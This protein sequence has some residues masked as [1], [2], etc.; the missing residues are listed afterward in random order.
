MRAHEDEERELIAAVRNLFTLPGRPEAGNGDPTNGSDETAPLSHPDEG[1]TREEAAQDTDPSGSG[2]DEEQSEPTSGPAPKRAGIRSLIDA[3]TGSG[4]TEDRHAA[5][6]GD[7]VRALLNRIERRRVEADAGGAPPLPAAEGIEAGPEMPAILPR[8]NDSSGILSRMK[9]W[10]EAD[11]LDVDEPGPDEDLNA[12]VVSVDDLGNLADLIL[13]KSATFAVEELNINRDDHHFD[14]VDNARVVSEFDDLFARTV[15]SPAF[16]AAAAQVAIP[17]EEGVQPR[18]GFLKKFQFPG[19]GEAI[20]E[21]NS[22]FHGPLVDLSMRPSPGL[23]EIELYPVN[24]PY[25]YVRVT[26]DGTTH[27]YTYHVLEPVL[28]PG[29]QEL[30]GEI[31]ERLF[32]TLDITTRDLTREAARKALRDSANTIIADYGIHLTP[33]GRE[34]ILYHVEKEFLGDGL[35]DPVMHDKY[36]EDISCD[37]VNSPIF[38]YHTTYESMKTSLVYRD[39][40]DLDSFVTKLAQRAGKYISIAEPMLDATMSDGSRIQMTLGA[41]VTAHGSTFTI[42]KFREE[43]ITPTDLI[44]WHTF[45]PLG[46]AFIWLAVENAKSCIFAGG[47]ASGK[48]TTLNA[49]SLFIP[50]LAKIVTLEDTR[51]LKLPHPNWIPSITRDSFSQDGRGEIDMYELLRAA[52]RQR[53]EYILVGEVRGREALTL[54]QAM[55]TGHVTYATMHADSVASAVHRLENPPIDVPRNML[56]ALSLMSIQVQAR[57]GG[58]RIRRNKQLIEILDIDPRTNELIT[59]EVFRWHPATDEIRYSGKSYILEQIMEDRG[60]SEE[61]MQEELKRRQEVLEWMRI[62]K[63]RYF[64]DV[65][66]ILV[67]YFRDPETV[68][69]RV[70]SDL[71]GEDGGLA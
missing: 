30:F 3:V 71:Y 14:F 17:A 15:S 49:I 4:S 57:V 27:E 61:R 55:S 68:I 29:E 5:G 33:P 8:Q 28:T 6:G 41:E 11:T 42:R 9:G 66:K 39:A 7:P 22:T 51:E 59:N 62:K 60:W 13:P 12:G 56:S 34:K 70:R 63:I 64:R 37:G 43:P 58:Q 54:F 47:T 16:V 53:P 21:Y 50:P 19:A 10:R 48:T 67:S 32:E 52:L 31:K 20:E 69:E 2:G 44:E 1:E 40:A 45:S 25:A 36:I 24:E 18:F 46:I 35:I 38:V 23:E 65:S 26:Y